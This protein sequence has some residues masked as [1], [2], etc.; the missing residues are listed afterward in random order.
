MAPLQNQL[1][2]R[3]IGAPILAG[4]GGGRVEEVLPVLQIEDGARR[5][6]ES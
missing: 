1:V 4:E 2:G 5:S 6:P 3:D